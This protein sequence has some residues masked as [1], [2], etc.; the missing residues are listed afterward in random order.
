[1]A[2]LGFLFGHISQSKIVVA[3]QKSEV[4]IVIDDF[5]GRAGAIEEMMNLPY[6]LNLQ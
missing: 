3:P 5:G 4:A 2:S 6:P 1:M